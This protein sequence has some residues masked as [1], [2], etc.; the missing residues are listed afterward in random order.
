MP[1]SRIRFRPGAPLAALAL[2]LL[3][4]MGGA[5][6]V[7]LGGP[8]APDGVAPPRPHAFPALLPDSAENTSVIAQNDGDAPSVMVM[9]FHT[10]GGVLITAA[11]QVFTNVP[12]GG[13]RTFAHA[14]NGG[15]VP[16]FRGAG[17]LS[18]DQPMNA[19]LTREIT[20]P[21]GVR[22]YSIHTATA[23]GGMRVVLPYVA[24]RLETASGDAI[25]TRLA[26]A[27]GSDRVACIG[28]TY[29]FHPNRGRLGPEGRRTVTDR[30]VYD[31]I[32]PNGGRPIQ[33][34][35]QLTLAPTRVDGALPMPAVARNTL[36][37]VTIDATAPVTVAADVY[38]RDGRQLAAYDGFLAG[39]RDSATDDLSTRMILPIAQKTEDG[40]WTEYVF[41]NPWREAT[42]ARITYTGAA[43]EG[44][45]PVT[46]TVTVEVPAGA[47][48]G[49]D[50]R[51]S[52]ELPDGFR[53]SAVIES[54]LPLAAVL[55]RGKTAEAGAS[56]EEAPFA[57]VN[58]V[59]AERAARTL[60]LPLIFRNA[61]RTDERDGFNS[62]VS[63]A[64]ADGGAA[65][66]RITA[67][68][69]PTTGMRGCAGA[70][71][72]TATVRVT[73]SILLDQSLDDPALNGLNAAPACLR[74][75]MTIA[76]DRAIVAVA[77]VTSDL[78]AGDN[79]ALYNAFR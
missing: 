7:A 21:D 1:L 31:R 66:L 65:N 72:Y 62:S 34:N 48:R 19:L 75:G 2:L 32:C 79:D 54:G 63:I 73:G 60:K 12:P 5:A 9:D 10:P 22:S 16:G 11:S 51:D 20:G 42:T 74:G 28:L 47:G 15:L 23:R 55:L 8:S 36:M 68:N 33:P 25:N 35:G 77:G 50:V 69:D 78:W 43:D 3:A 27:N 40:S 59:P 24:N 46:V 13:S 26:I 37:A 52:A 56:G 58:G 4:A 67:A 61:E 18:S 38:R 57:A 17:T 6:A 14:L 41:M 53:G 70:A 45:E 76:S 44:R 39:A 71:V 64:V 29:A 49:H 30:S